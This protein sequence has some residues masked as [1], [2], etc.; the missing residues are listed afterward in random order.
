MEASESPDLRW[1]RALSL[2]ALSAALSVALLGAS[3][4]AQL[5]PGVQLSTGAVG[6]NDEGAWRGASDVVAWLRFDR[7]WLTT[8]LEGAAAGESRARW[9]YGGLLTATIWAPAWSGL[10]PSFSF[11]GAQQNAPLGGSVRE[12]QG[13]VRLGYHR[14]SSGVWVGGGWGDAKLVAAASDAVRTT[15]APIL[16]AGWSTEF[17]GWH[18]F[19]SAIVRLSVSSRARTLDVSPGSPRAVAIGPLHYDPRSRTYLVDTV[20]AEPDRWTE[21]EV[22]AY[23]AHGPIT[24]DA[25]VGR[26]LTGIATGKVWTR[27][28]ASIA[29]D[30]RLALVVGGGA[31][32]PELALLAPDRRRFTLGFRFSR[33]PL[34]HAEAPAI[35]PSAAAFRV[36]RADARRARIRVRVPGARTVELG[37]DFTGWRPVQLERGGPDDWTVTLPIAPGTYHVNLRVNGG[38]WIAPPGLARVHDDFAGVVGLVVVP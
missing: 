36:E 11:A 32:P 26:P 4:Q 33:A 18:Q 29:L 14:A 34:R 13:V 27:L 6:S 30:Q 37:A 17:G 1:A 7:P 8:T 12:S 23:W 3:A 38:T 22:G 9:A 28:D 24:L 20:L 19:G 5:A 21:A 16:P 15:P 10:R 25:A 31:A 35:E 2:A